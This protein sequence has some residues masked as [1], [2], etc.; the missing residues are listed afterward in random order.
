MVHRYRTTH[1]QRS[2]GSNVLFRVIDTLQ[3]V[4]RR[5]SREVRRLQRRI[6]DLEEELEERRIH[7]VE[8]V[9]ENWQRDK[10]YLRLVVERNRLRAH[11]AN[12]ENRLRNTRVGRNN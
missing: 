6:S 4:N 8:I 9:T 2:N 5:L 1:S 7:A 12:L 3:G 10:R 11:V